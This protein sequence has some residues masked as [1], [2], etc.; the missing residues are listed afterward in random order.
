MA[1][2]CL[3][4]GKSGSLSITQAMKLST[5]EANV[6]ISCFIKSCNLTVKYYAP[7]ET[8]DEFSLRL[9]GKNR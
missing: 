7:K 8:S 6:R 5:C 2:N 1:G 4:Q 9:S 3:D